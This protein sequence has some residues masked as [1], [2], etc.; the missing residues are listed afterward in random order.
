V[1]ARDPVYVVIPETMYNVHRNTGMRLRD[2]DYA[3]P[4]Y[5]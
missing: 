2:C 1:R 4:R 5:T 3:S